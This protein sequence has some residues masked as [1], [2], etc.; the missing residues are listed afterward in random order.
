MKTT[1]RLEARR[2]R[3]HE[4]LSMK[5]IASIVGVSL[6][7]V[8]LWVR[9][10]ELDAVKNASMRSRAARRRG[11]ARAAHA[12][13][14]RRDAQ[15]RGRERAV[16]GD[17]LHLAGCMLFWAEGDKHRNGV[18]GYLSRASAVRSS[19][20]TRSTARRNA[21][22]SFRMGPARWHTTTHAQCSRSTAR[23]RSTAASTAPHGSASRL[24]RRAR[25]SPVPAVGRWRRGRPVRSGRPRPSRRSRARRP[26]ACRPAR[27]P[28]R[29]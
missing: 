3:E 14:L 17:P 1:E 7:S 10:I 26:C 23:S 12:R 21:A 29:R 11:E 4:G 6:S 19:T 15:G 24:A 28:P 16:H 2:L 5:Q 27:A 22:T 25:S 20:S 9:D 18:S 13:A 8:S